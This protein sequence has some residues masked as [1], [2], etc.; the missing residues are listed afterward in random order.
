MI[1]RIAPPANS[2]QALLCALAGITGEV[3]EHLET[4]GSFI[5]R[6]FMK[7][8]ACDQE[9]IVQLQSFD[10]MCQQL[11]AVAEMLEDCAVLIGNDDAPAHKIDSI[12]AQIPMRQ[13]RHR[14]QDALVVPE[15]E[16]DE[17]E[18]ADEAEF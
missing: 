14:L 15:P 6:E 3:A 16:T 13:I 11:T 8:A 1:S 12:I 17:K 4:T 7:S 18:P 2:M 5:G 9:V 10:R